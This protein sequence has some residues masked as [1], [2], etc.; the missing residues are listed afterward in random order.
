MVRAESISPP[1]L[2]AAAD[3]CLVLLSRS[4]VA[5]WAV[6][7]PGLEWDVRGTVEHLVDVLGF[8][9]LH[10][11]AASPERLRIDVRSHDGITNTEVL[12]LAIIEAR[13]LA[14]AAALLDP[15]TR[16]FHFHGTTDVSGI[17]ALACAELLVHGHDAARGLGSAR[18]PRPDL[19]EGPRPPFPRCASGERPLVHA[20]VGDRTRLARRAP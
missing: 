15:S 2:V 17:L 4:T 20:A 1:D 3:H 18:A 9:T 6:P 14:T 11:V 7:V 19:P 5:D 12:R 8:Y 16:V 10:L 13:G